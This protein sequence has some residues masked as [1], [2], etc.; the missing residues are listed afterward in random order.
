MLSG[1]RAINALRNLRHCIIK[2]I[3]HV[4]SAIIAHLKPSNT[5]IE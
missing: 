4:G 2:T 5:M 1:L 3:S